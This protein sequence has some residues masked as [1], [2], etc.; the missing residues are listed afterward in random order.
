[1]LP[2]V[3][4]RVFRPT[5]LEVLGLSNL[6]LGAAYSAYG[7]V[8]V[9][10]YFL[11]GPIADRFGPRRLIVIALLATAA[12]GLVYTQRPSAAWLVALYAW[13]GLTTILL[14]WA[15]MLRA[16]REWGGTG[17][18]GRAFGLLEGG[19]G[20][21]SALLAT[22]S[23]ALFSALLPGDSALVTAQDRAAAFDSVTLAAT[24]TL[25]LAAALIA[26]V[27]PESAAAASRARRSAIKDLRRLG[28][29]PTVWL[30][31]LVIVCAYFAYRATDLYSQYASDVFGYDAVS[32][33]GVGAMSLWLRPVGAVLAGWIADRWSASRTAA[34]AFG[35]VAVASLALAFPSAESHLPA[36]VLAI[37]SAS[38]GI[39]ALR[40]IYF[41]LTAEAKVPLALT[42][43]AVGLVSV[44]GYTPDIFAG[45]VYGYLL[46]RTPGAGGFRDVFLLVRAC[47]LVG[48]AASA[49]F[50]RLTRAHAGG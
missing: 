49:A 15:A 37:A 29:M 16:T 19:R 10:A 38:L 30:Q 22:A 35:L 44:I 43:T 17:A 23:V 28:A 8:A 2:F 12:G 11:G 13:W 39:F 14:F 24:G 6:Q 3:L 5:L 40:G 25:V 1:M 21:V 4:A 7:L 26:A 45:P 48:L 20:L 27:L 41:A 9:G 33:A 18:Q 42:G 31:A 36:A 32:A 47:A 34:L 50:A 46:D